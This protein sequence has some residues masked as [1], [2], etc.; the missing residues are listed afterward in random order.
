MERW[1]W[2]ILAMLLAGC[3]GGGLEKKDNEFTYITQ[4]NLSAPAETNRGTEITVK[5]SGTL[6]V[7]G[8]KVTITFPAAWNASAAVYTLDGSMPWV[9]ACKVTVPASCPV[10]DYEIK[11]NLY[12]DQGNGRYIKGAD[13]AIVKVLAPVAQDGPQG[14]ANSP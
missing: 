7:A 8:P 6:A 3:G 12:Y 4:I 9:I 10:D 1:G 11:A 2:M 13:T 5:V 14:L